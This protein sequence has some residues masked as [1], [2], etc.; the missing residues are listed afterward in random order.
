MNWPA[1]N[2]FSQVSSL[3]AHGGYQVS[4]PM[5]MAPP[6]VVPPQATVSVALQDPAK[7]FSPHIS[8]PSLRSPAQIPAISSH[9]QLNLNSPRQQLMSLGQKYGAPRRNAQERL[10]SQMSVSEAAEKAIEEELR[11]LDLLCEL[12]PETAA[13][14]M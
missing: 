8:R 13:D 9:F 12:S 3:L 7:L 5:R 14:E 11:C 6:S 2:R 4:Q 1:T 10:R